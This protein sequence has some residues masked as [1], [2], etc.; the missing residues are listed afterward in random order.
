MTNK[1]EYN[2]ERA[3]MYETAMARYPLARAMDLDT[4]QKI[5]APA[6][7]D[8]VLGIGEGNGYFC[9]PILKA[10]GRTGR[11]AVVDP[12]HHQLKN[13]KN[14][15]DVSQLEVMAVGAHEID[16][17]D[18][19]FD[20]IWSFGAFH[21]CDLQEEAMKRMYRSLKVGGK[22]VICDVFQGSVLADHFDE[23]VA[24]Y[25]NT[26]HN[27]KFMSDRMAKS[28]AYRA[29]F[30]EENVDIVELP[31]KWYF[32]SEEDVGRFIYGLHAMTGIKG[33]TESEKIEAVY[34]GCARILGVTMENSKYALNWP[35]KALVVKK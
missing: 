34:G 23:Q 17:A 14:R 28:L 11:Y 15:V 31:Q 1:I 35:M 33:I 30:K 26:G 8:V 13:L 12:S 3:A 2:D 10:I 18:G 9:E 32:D 22:A 16:F 4:M 27:V 24:R 19:T 29:G 7:G 21:H 20:K 5:L 6:I 25:C